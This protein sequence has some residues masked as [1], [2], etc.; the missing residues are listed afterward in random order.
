LFRRAYLGY[1]VPSVSAFA[2]P[3][4]FLRRAYLGYFVPSVSAFAFRAALPP[5]LPR[6][7]RPLGLGFRLMKRKS[8]KPVCKQTL[9]VLSFSRGSLLSV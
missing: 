9:S 4:P 8:G 3:A 1:F 2:F 6:V 5:R 7:L